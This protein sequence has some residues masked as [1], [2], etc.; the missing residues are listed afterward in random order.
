M[1]ILQPKS[2]TMEEVKFPVSRIVDLEQG[3]SALFERSLLPIQRL[4]DTLGE[5]QYQNILR[6]NRGVSFFVA[7][8]K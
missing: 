4:L 1:V 8:Y 7:M 2:E 5:L 6:I 3:C